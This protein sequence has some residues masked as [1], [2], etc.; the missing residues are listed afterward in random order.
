MDSIDFFYSAITLSYLNQT[1]LSYGN[2]GILIDMW[3]LIQAYINSE[4]NVYIQ[5]KYQQVDIFNQDEQYQIFLSFYETYDDEMSQLFYQNSVPFNINNYNMSSTIM[6][7]NYVFVYLDNFWPICQKI[8]IQIS[9]YI[10]FIMLPWL[11]INLNVIVLMST[12]QD[13]RYYKKVQKALIQLF[14][15]SERKKQIGICSVLYKIYFIPCTIIIFLVIMIDLIYV[16]TILIQQSN[17]NSLQ[18][19]IEY[20][21]STCAL[22]GDQFIQSLQVK[23]RSLI[24][25]LRDNPSNCVESLFNHQV[26]LMIMSEFTI[27]QYLKEYPQYQ[28]SFRYKLISKGNRDYKILMNNNQPDWFQQRLNN[29]ISQIIMLNLDLEVKDRH[30]PAKLFNQ[31]IKSIIIQNNSIQLIQIISIFMLIIIIQ[32][33][34]IQ[35]FLQKARTPF[36]RLVKQ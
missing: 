28:K 10:G 3:Q 4:D 36:R 33:S 20:G 14:G 2:Q 29:A 1:P 9:I 27:L 25:Y 21:V 6:T 32:Y 34:K 26:Q 24:I 16:I 30:L 13:V 5:T 35:Q 11:L 23:D 15:S 19:V 7:E 31:Q 22:N 17:F 18:D 12:E 8:F